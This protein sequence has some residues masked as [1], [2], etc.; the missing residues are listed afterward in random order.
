MS[1]QNPNFPKNLDIRPSKPQGSSS[2]LGDAFNTLAQEDAIR[3]YGIAGR[4]W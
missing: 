1:L 4:V 2:D 3:Q